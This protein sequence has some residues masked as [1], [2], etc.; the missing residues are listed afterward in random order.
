[1]K[2][3]ISLTLF[4]GILICVIGIILSMIPST[5]NYIFNHKE[6]ETWKY[7][8]KNADKFQI[9]YINSTIAIYIWEQY[10]P[11]IWENGLCSIHTENGE[12]ITSTFNEK[13]SKQMA[14]K[15]KLWKKL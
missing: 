11:I 9:G 5:Y 14:A 12:C 2:E 8:I 3:I 10:T 6:W 4:I 13:L 1:M 7:F 15:L